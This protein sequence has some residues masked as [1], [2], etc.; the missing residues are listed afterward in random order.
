MR[1]LMYIAHWSDAHKPNP[2]S[3]TRI[4]DADASGRELAQA[5]HIDEGSNTCRDLTD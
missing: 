2:C 3:Y 5:R 1:L 4:W